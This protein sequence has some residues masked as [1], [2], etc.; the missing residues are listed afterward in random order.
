MSLGRVSSF[1]GKFSKLTPPDFFVRKAVSEI[2]KEEKINISIEKISLN[3][4]GVVFIKTNNYIKNK[5]FINKK[6]LIKEINKH[7]KKNIIK[8]IF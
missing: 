4:E 7:L 8:D 5:I 2:L 1:L 3:K 6:K